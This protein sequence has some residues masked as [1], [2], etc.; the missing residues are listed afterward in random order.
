MR[1]YGEIEVSPKHNHI[2]I[3]DQLCATAVQ[4]DLEMA[5]RERLAADRGLLGW[6]F[7]ILGSLG[8]LIFECQEVILLTQNTSLMAWSRGIVHRKVRHLHSENKGKCQRDR[9][10][11]P[12]EGG[13]PISQFW[14]D[15][16]SMFRNPKNCCTDLE[17]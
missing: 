13:P 9:P 15:Y 8:F 17:T 6:Y 3:H 2:G 16:G 4:Q 10:A 5:A 1:P 14:I 12:G 7:D 11:R